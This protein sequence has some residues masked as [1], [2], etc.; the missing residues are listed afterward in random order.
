MMLYGTTE[1]QLGFWFAN[2]LH[3]QVPCILYVHV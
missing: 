1:L 3:A 2:A